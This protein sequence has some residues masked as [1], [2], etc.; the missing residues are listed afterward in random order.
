M[1]LNIKSSP[2]LLVVFLI[3]YGCQ[4]LP[5]VGSVRLSENTVTLKVWETK[6]LTATVE[7]SG[8]EY[9]RITWSS[10]D[11]TVAGVSNGLIKAYK[12]GVTKIT[13]STEG[14][15]SLPCEVTVTSTPVT[16]VQLDK[17]SVTIN[18]GESLTLSATVSPYNATDKTITW[19]SSDEK[20][21]TVSSSGKVTAITEG[22]VTIYAR[23]KDGGS[24][25]SCKV[26]VTA[27]EVSFPDANFRM[28]MLNNFDLN[29]N[30]KISVSEAEKVNAIQIPNNSEIESLQGI[31]YCVNLTIL[32]V[33]HSYSTSSGTNQD[34]SRWYRI[35][36][37]GNIKTLDLSRNVKLQTLYCSGNQLKALDVSNNTVLTR[38]NCGANQLTTLVVS[39]NTVLTQ[40][41][42]YYN[43]LSVLDISK[44]TELRDLYCYD[45]QLTAL[46]VSKNSV[47]TQ[48]SCS[49]NQL[50][51]LDVTKNTMLQNLN[52]GSNKITTL[53]VSHNTALTQLSC[54]SN[55]LTALDVSKN[56]ALQFLECGSNKITTLDVSKNTALT[57]LYCY[58]NQL[59][60]LD[61][62]KNTMLQ[63]LNCGSNK[64]TTLNVSHNTALTGLQCYFNQ[65]TSLDMTK[66]NK[67]EYLYCY[68]NQLT[69]LDVTKNTALT[70]LYCYYNKLTSLDVS[71]NPN[72]Q[73]LD[74]NP[75]NNNA[76]RSLYMASGQTV[77]KTFDVPSY[78]TIVRR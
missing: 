73:Y 58:N 19:S 60:A 72:L 7:P 13:A 62:T 49:N 35:N 15:T 8:A 26:T 16:G 3:V 77:S 29:K 23:A 46:D 36:N 45:N 27:E 78:T 25:A 76:L 4:W 34:G 68:Y 20:I 61:V 56:T 17:T 40:L 31:E 42:C 65:L 10:S 64:I 32:N 48:L 47:L 6:T 55:Q 74:C 66:N 75:M 39:K 12:I 57:S 33:T 53:N 52:C 1:K 24:V 14:V 22:V 30:G 70:N 11:P 50:T 21:A 71:K 59:T 69:S 44:N 67:L 18:E 54:Y 63:Y 37:P 43:Q 38:L 28:Y 51:A 2:F 5:E 41:S 9:E